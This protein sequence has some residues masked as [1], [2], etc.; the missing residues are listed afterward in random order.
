MKRHWLVITIALLLVAAGGL[1]LLDY[2][3]GRPSVDSD[4]AAL[5]KRA[6]ATNAVSISPSGFS[7]Q[8]VEVSPGTTVSWANND[9]ISHTITADYPDGKNAPQSADI[10]QGQTY[11]FTFHQRGVYHYH[12]SRV[13][14]LSGAVV[15]D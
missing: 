4:V 2:R 11:S 6:V 9:T 14:G 5:L 10:A 15:V 12:C 3:A 8:V 13:G 7:P 1:L